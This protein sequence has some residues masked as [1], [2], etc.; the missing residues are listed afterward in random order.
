[1]ASV[2]KPKRIKLFGSDG[3]EVMFL[4]KGGEDLRNDER[5]ELLF[6]LMNSVI[7]SSA[8]TSSSSSSSSSS[9]SS[10][11][12]N[13]KGSSLRARTYTVIPMTSQV[14]ILEWVGNTSPIKAVVSDEMALDTAF[15]SANAEFNE[16]KDLSSADAFKVRTDWVGGHEAP[17]Y[18]KMFRDASEK[19]ARAV[20]LKVSELLPED[21]I[22]RRLLKVAVGPEAFVT[23]RTEFAKTLAVSSL[24]GY[25]LG[26]GDRHL[27]NLLLDN[28][29]G[30][31]IQIDFGICFGMG[32]SVLGVPELIPFRLSPQLIA[33]LQPLDGALLLRHY[34]VR[35][36]TC[37]RADEGFQILSNALQV[38]I[39]DPLLDWVGELSER[40][41]EPRRRV[42]SCLRKL[43][44]AD[45]GSIMGEDLG[46]NPS[47]RRE[48]SLSALVGIIKRACAG[49][50]GE[51]SAPSPSEGRSPSDKGDVI[52]TVD[53][54]VDS[55]MAL[56]TNPDVAIRQWIGLATW[57]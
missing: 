14:G 32:Q 46:L 47:V 6:G 31:I 24:F 7:S 43:K 36:M 45:P 40:D 11:Q 33:V 25:I 26:L 1:M 20:S 30:A 35:A 12:D 3:S 22:R 38:Y 8:S 5:I 19:N 16:G 56:A 41:E 54:Q 28:R 53:E 39:N 21:F 4:V 52:L 51:R 13:S 57:I 44:G 23:L 2:R 34:M 42:E 18:H 37:L 10:M 49:A 55:L 27:D 15:C 9:T 48:K 29:T 50:I 17:K